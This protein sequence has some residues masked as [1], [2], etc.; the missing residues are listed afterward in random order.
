MD[1][2]ISSI[3]KRVK[4]ERI[5]SSYL[6]N[7]DNKENNKTKELSNRKEDKDIQTEEVNKKI[8]INNY[9]DN[10]KK[11]LFLIHSRFNNNKNKNRRNDVENDLIPNTNVITLDGYNSLGNESRKEGKNINT[12]KKYNKQLNMNK[13]RKFWKLNSSEE[14]KYYQE[15]GLKKVNSN[16]AI[17]GI[18]NLKRDKVHLIDPLLFDKFKVRFNNK[19]FNT[20]E[21]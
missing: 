1:N 16:K 13:F 5:L 14:K 3:N 10:K 21:N 9:N 6:I 17:N 12:N 7:D 18:Y 8:Y 15:K 19:K 4:R 2:I 20:I 11:D